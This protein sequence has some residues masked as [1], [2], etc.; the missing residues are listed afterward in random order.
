[1]NSKFL[2]LDLN[3]KVLFDDMALIFSTSINL[4]I[5]KDKKILVTGGTGTIMSY[6]ILFLIYLNL[7]YKFNIKVKALIRNRDKFF[8]IFRKYLEL[9]FLSYE[10]VDLNNENELSNLNFNADIVIHAA[11]LASRKHYEKYPIQTILPNIIGT[12]NLLSYSLKKKVNSFIFLS[13]NNVY[14]ESKKRNI[15]EEFSGDLDY[16]KFYNYY[17]QSKRTGELLCKAFSEQEKLKTIVL[18]IHHTYG[19]TIDLLN[20]DRVFSSFLKDALFTKTIKINSNG[21]AF[22]SFTYITDTVSGLIT[23]LNSNKTFNVL[24]IANDK[25]FSS[26]EDL[27]MIISK[28]SDSKIL[29]LNKIIKSDKKI[30]FNTKSS[31]KKLRNYGWTPKVSNLIGFRKTYLYFKGIFKLKDH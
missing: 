19:P 15:D 1:M 23:S 11:S 22:R 21:K 12:Y 9:D 26:V 8:E 18:R 2:G 27:A 24:N 10:I 14:G 25:N 5:L 7:T 3:N 16:L 6:F 28:F 4:E 29:F 17:G 30:N 20:D 31:V 13:T